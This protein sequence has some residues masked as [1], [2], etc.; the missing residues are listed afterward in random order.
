MEV[1]QRFLSSGGRS[2]ERVHRVVEPELD[3]YRAR[4]QDSSWPRYLRELILWIL[5][6]VSSTNPV[7]KA[8]KRSIGRELEEDWPPI[9]R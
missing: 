6:P 3:M 2:P 9:E 1:R 4:P 7:V 5:S 8:P